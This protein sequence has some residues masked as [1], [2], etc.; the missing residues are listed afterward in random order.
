MTITNN[1]IKYWN[2]DEESQL[3]DEINNL[4]DI[5]QIL[6][7]HDRKITGITMR[8]EKLLNDPKFNDK[9]INK[10]DI[11]TK[12]LKK[13]ST[14]SSNPNINVLQSPNV[15]TVFTTSPTKY[16][17]DYDDLYNRILEFNFIE[18]ISNHY[19]VTINKIKIILTNLLNNKKDIDMTKKLRI[20]CLLNSVGNGTNIDGEDLNTE[21]LK[22]NIHNSNNIESNLITVVL[23][24]LN[25]IKTMK[26]DIFDIQQRNKVIMDKICKIENYCSDKDKKNKPTKIIEK[27]YINEIINNEKNNKLIDD[28]KNIEIQF[29]KNSTNNIEHSKKINIIAD[30]DTDTDIELTHIDINKNIDF[31]NNNP[32]LDDSDFKII[33]YTNN[34]NNNL[35]PTIKT[36]KSIKTNK[37]NKHKSNINIQID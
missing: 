26:I 5:N 32:Q 15:S 10:N 1:K 4:T 24:L 3:I 7:N 18:E 30:T 2:Y 37:I 9:I 33:E 27:N 20:K 35:T 34:N 22:T 14:K 25:E 19:N 29:N 12:Y 16:Y 28:N 21:T 6:T 17:I 31:Y 23:D 8:I 36:K 11:I 13:S